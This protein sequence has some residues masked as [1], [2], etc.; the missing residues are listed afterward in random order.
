MDIH[1]WR[2]LADTTTFRTYPLVAGRPVT[3][4]SA[5][6]FAPVSPRDG[7][8]LPAVSMADESVVDRA[9]A[10]ARA[11]VVDRRWSGMSPQ[12]R[13]AVLQHLADLVEDQG[14]Q[15]AVTISIEMG[16]PAHDALAVEVRALASCL[17]WYGEICGKLADECPTVGDDA[18]AL[19]TREPAG[20]VAAVLPWNFPLTLAGWKIGPALAAG[21]SL[22]VKPA[23]QT[24]YS[25]LL[26]AELALAAGVPEGVLNVVPGTGA[27]AGRALGLHPDVD[28]LTFTGST[29]VGRQFQRYAAESNGKR[30]WL[31][32]GGKSATV[33]LAD[34]DLAAAGSTAA[35]GA[36]YNAGQMCSASSRLVVVDSVADEVIE[37]AVARAEAMSPGD[38]LGRDAA[39]G[40]IV[41]SAKAAAVAEVIDLATAGGATI[42]GSGAVPSDLPE[43]GSYVAPVVLT[44]VH[45]RASVAQEEIFGPVLS[46]IR[47]ADA[48]AAVR[49]A[50]DTAYGLAASVWT[51]DLD[52]AVRVS[53]SLRAGTVWVNCYEEGDMTMPFG[54]VAGS[55]YGRDKSAHALDKFTDLKSTWIALG[56]PS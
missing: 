4:T 18:L 39:M 52:S 15:L 51:R 46:V 19:V 26:L 8:S 23:E 42:A 45:P 10:A 12:A 21:N 13:G 44:D 16:K 24:P 20:V 37:H 29:A 27:I 41:S 3:D 35:W 53:R 14:P 32:L 30:V 33:V 34:A 40:A 25:A 11:A 1:D 9:V 22:V 47:V 49:V 36:F 50:N 6:P 38:P 54:G 2:A 43:R 55:G 5:T 28:V 31:E 48:D 7:R 17:R 56:S